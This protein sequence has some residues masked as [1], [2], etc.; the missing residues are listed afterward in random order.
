MR[1]TRLW[2][3]AGSPIIQGRSSLKPPFLRELAL[4]V[5]FAGVIAGA[6]HWAGPG[7]RELSWAAAA[8]VGDA[9]LSGLLFG[10]LP[11][12][13]VLPIVRAMNLK[14]AWTLAAVAGGGAAIAVIVFLPGL[15]V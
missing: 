2:Q 5:L 10:W 9:V 11:A 6:Y 3:A 7:A 1:G 15:S 12:L 13:I 14:P 4:A 8:G